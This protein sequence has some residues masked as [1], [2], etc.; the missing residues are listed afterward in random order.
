MHRLTIRDTIGS[1]NKHMGGI[2]LQSN[3]PL[4]LI[5]VI[6]LIINIV[7]L[8]KVEYLNNQ[9]QNLRHDYNNLQS[10]ISSISGNV[11]SNL[12]RFTREQSWITPVQVDDGKTRV[13]GQQGLAVL[14]WQIKDYKEGAEVVFHYR[15]N[16]S[17]EFE[18]VP[19]K[20]K[21]DGFF[22]VEIPF[23]I[24]VEPYWEVDVS[25]RTMGGTVTS[26]KKVKAPGPDY[27]SVSYYVSMKTGDVIRSSEIA[28]VDVAYL[29]K[30]K[31]EPIVG[32]VDINNN[33][34]HISV[35]DHNTGSNDFHSAMAVF[36]NGSKVVAEKAM[37]VRDVHDS[38]KT[39]T[40]DYVADSQD[41]SHL[42]I[43]VKYEDG[44]TFEKEIF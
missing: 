5:I 7:L 9:I 26:E 34:Y 2:Q 39:Y 43:Q 32:H 12:D 11:N 15:Q 1:D 27:Q 24:R 28:Y 19:A 14:N 36:Y 41:I 18:T 4:L 10:S 16:E 13:D 44:K 20:N 22:E 37:E 29:A 35:F 33:K 40:L 21:G 3:R 6:V 8:D 31:Y 25:K 30:L 23:D 17:E 42:V 38:G